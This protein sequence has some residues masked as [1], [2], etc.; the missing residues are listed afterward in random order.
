MSGKKDEHDRLVFTA[1]RDLGQKV[2]TIAFAQGS[3]TRLTVT[4]EMPDEQ[5]NLVIPG[6]GK[7]IRP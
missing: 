3:M 1:A 4:W 7:E 5:F 2:E 6:L